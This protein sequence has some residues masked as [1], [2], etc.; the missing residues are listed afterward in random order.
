MRSGGTA[1]KIVK[2]IWYFSFLF[3]AELDVH[4]TVHRVKFLKIKPTR[5][6]NF[7]DLFFE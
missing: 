5:C 1:E 6:T 2:H 4:V 7:S 3:L